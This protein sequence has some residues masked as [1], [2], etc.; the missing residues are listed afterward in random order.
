MSHRVGSLL[1]WS[2]VGKV[3]VVHC[4]VLFVFTSQILCSYSILIEFAFLNFRLIQ[5]FKL[6]LAYFSK[7][8]HKYDKVW[9]TILWGLLDVGGLQHTTIY[10]TQQYWLSLVC[11]WSPCWLCHCAGIIFVLDLSLFRLLHQALLHITDGLSLV[12]SL[13]VWL[14]FVNMVTLLLQV[15]H[16]T[17]CEVAIALMFHMPRE[18]NMQYYFVVHPFMLQWWW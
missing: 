14:T 13:F 7:C 6:F 15:R 4:S 10:T 11:L 2:L 17:H 18:F 8:M 1:L 12:Y 5:M 9:F 3:L 16:G